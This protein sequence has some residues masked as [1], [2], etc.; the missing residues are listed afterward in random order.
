MEPRRPRYSCGPSVLAR[1]PRFLDIRLP[2]AQS[3]SYSTAEHVL[4]RTSVEGHRKRIIPKQAVGDCQ[5]EEA[6]T[7]IDKDRLLSAIRKRA[8]HQERANRHQEQV[9]GREVDRQE[10]SARSWSLS[11]ARN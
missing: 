2:P 10:G 8:E 5:E 1:S 3:A 7:E 6:K 9:T 11:Q 4:Q